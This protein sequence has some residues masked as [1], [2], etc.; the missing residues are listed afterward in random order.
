MT[1]SSFLASDLP[2][3]HLAF[4][5]IGDEVVRTVF[6]LYQRERALIMI[7]RTGTLEKV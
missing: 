5:S 4:P 7:N 3:D 2:G 6:H 1:G